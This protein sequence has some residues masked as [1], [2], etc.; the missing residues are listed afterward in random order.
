MMRNN[1]AMRILPEQQTKNKND[2]DTGNKYFY[3]EA[4]FIFHEVLVW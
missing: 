2:D 3:C 4:L 1:A